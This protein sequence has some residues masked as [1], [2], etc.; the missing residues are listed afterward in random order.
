[1][2]IYMIDGYAPDLVKVEIFMK[3][4]LSLTDSNRKEGASY[5]SLAQREMFTLKAEHLGSPILCFSHTQ[6]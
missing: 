5:A 4:I 2:F 6:G 1:M 3:V